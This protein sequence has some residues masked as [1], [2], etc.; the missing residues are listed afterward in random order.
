MN[1]RIRSEMVRHIPAAVLLA[2]VVSL[3]CSRGTEVQEEVSNYG[4]Q[5]TDATLVVYTLPG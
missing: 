5:S 1:H 4:G 2:L 3:G